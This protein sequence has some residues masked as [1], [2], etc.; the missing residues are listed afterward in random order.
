MKVKFLNDINGRLTPFLTESTSSS[1]EGCAIRID[2]EVMEDVIGL[3]EAGMD[4]FDKIYESA[5]GKTKYYSFKDKTLVNVSNYK[6]LYVVTDTTINGQYIADILEGKHI[7]YGESTK[8][9]YVVRISVKARWCTR[10]KKEKE[11]NS[12]QV[13][14]GRVLYEVGQGHDINEIFDITDKKQLHHSK[15]CWDNRLESVKLLT[16]KEHQLEHKKT[17]DKKYGKTH[18]AA[19]YITNIGE[20]ISFIENLL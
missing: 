10:N 13:S 7:R 16:S 6:N 19:C 3:H 2:K 9:K 4:I 18:Q 11:S 8:G 14:L 1:F 17:Y 5:D 15:I 12:Y 20:L